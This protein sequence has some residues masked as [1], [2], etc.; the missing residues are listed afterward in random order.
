MVEISIIPG[1]KYSEFRKQ[2]ELKFLEETLGADVAEEYVQGF[3]EQEEM[4][5]EIKDAGDLVGSAR[6]EIG[7][8][9]FRIRAFILKEEYR[10]KGIGTKTMKKLEALAKEKGCHKMWLITNPNLRVVGLYT[11]LG[12]EVEALL[13]KNVAKQDELLMVKFIEDVREKTDK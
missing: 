13:K 12:W 9:L 1:N 8:G 3:S 11:R 5:L 4:T 2:E 7:G 10:G 6:I